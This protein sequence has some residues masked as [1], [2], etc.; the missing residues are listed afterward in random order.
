VRIDPDTL[1]IDP[2]FESDRGGPLPAAALSVAAIRFALTLPPPQN[3][4]PGDPVVLGRAIPRRPAA[5]L[6]GLVPRDGQLHVMLTVRAAQLRDHAGQISF[7]GGQVDQQDAGD[8]QAALRESLEELGIAPDPDQVL[9]TLPRFTTI[10]GFDVTP[11]VAMFDAPVA[12]CPNPAEVADTFEVPLA[13]LMN[14]A[15]HQRR[16]AGIDAVVRPIFSIEYHAQRRYLIWGA[17]AAMI[18]NLYLVLSAGH[19]L[20]MQFSPLSESP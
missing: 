14:G 19:A 13:Y 8:V 2:A 12:A 6:I 17:T 16:L 11:V 10:S 9:G 4:H 15:N 5:V 3:L 20:T 7:P 18:R 1:P